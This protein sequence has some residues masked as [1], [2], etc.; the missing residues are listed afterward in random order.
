MAALLAT[1]RRPTVRLWAEDSPFE[2]KEVHRRAATA[3]AS[4]G[5]AGT[6][7]SMRRRSRS[8]ARSSANRCAVG[9]CPTFRQTN[10][11]RAIAFLR[12]RIQSFNPPC[13][14]GAARLKVWQPDPTQVLDLART[15][16]S[17]IGRGEP[18]SDT[19]NVPTCVRDVSIPHPFLTRSPA[20]TASPRR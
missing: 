15:F 7:T 18:E 2:T 11:P 4:V 20:A 6:W 12:G 19:R 1:A 13:V 3:G 9:L 8:N 5:G 17:Q 10:S 16:A 14:C